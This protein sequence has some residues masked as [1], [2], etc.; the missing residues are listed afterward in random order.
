MGRA[1]VP[2]RTGVTPPATGAETS[3]TVPHDWQSPQRPTHFGA[4]HPH[5]VHRNV[6]FAAL[7]IPAR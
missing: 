4:V 2:D 5:S 3:S 6:R 7:A 1:G